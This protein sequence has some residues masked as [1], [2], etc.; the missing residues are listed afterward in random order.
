MSLLR[1][2]SSKPLVFC[3]ELAMVCHCAFPV[4][5]SILAPAFPSKRKI[6]YDRS[7]IM[8]PL[9]FW[10]GV[11]ANKSLLNEQVSQPGIIPANLLMPILPEYLHIK[12]W[13]EV[14]LV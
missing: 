6:L 4:S 11:D 8:M 1:L 13:R 9:E 14:Y 2:P 12:A 7:I 10:Q 3:A 5:Q